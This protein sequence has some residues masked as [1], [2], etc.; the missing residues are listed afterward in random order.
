MQR[1]DPPTY[2]IEREWVER[3]V[4]RLEAI[5]PTSPGGELLG[6]WRGWLARLDASADADLAHP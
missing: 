2:P 6:F 3:E 4:R 1:T 5:P